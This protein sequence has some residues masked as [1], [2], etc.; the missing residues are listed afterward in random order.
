MARKKIA[1][2]ITR[3]KPGQIDPPRVQ[4]YTLEVDRTMTVLDG[5][6]QIRFTQDATL[7]Y[8]HSC[9]HSACGTCACVING[10]ERLACTTQV[11]ALK[12]AT[13]TIE[14]LKGFPRLGD[15]VVDMTGFFKELSP[16]WSYLRVCDQHKSRAK[17]SG[18][19]QWQCFEN[20]IECGC[21]NSVCP[22]VRNQRQFMGPAAL[23]MIH[24]EMRKNEATREALLKRAAGPRG[25]HWCNRALACSR[26][27]PTQVY[28]ARHIA[29]LRRIIRSASKPGD[30]QGSPDM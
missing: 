24:T 3:Y 4:T 13:I 26:V 20:C 22:V 30:P 16:Q 28:P 18:I 2:D 29:D 1:F 23:A 15:L 9:H 7:M 17:P 6:E 27:C 11:L 5:L 19:G 14:P 10:V 25:E 8:R 12:T 21:C